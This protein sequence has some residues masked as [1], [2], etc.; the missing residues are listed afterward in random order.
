MKT[1]KSTGFKPIFDSVSTT[2]KKKST[3]LQTKP[4][5]ATT[6]TK[7]R[8]ITGYLNPNPKSTSLPRTDSKNHQYHQ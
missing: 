5:T 2:P 1:N 8:F 6:N 4:S 3:T 7:K